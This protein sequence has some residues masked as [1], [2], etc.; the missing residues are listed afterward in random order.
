[1]NF[2]RL[3]GAGAR[4]LGLASGLTMV[5][6]LAGVQAQTLAPAPA[7]VT[8]NQGAADAAAVAAAAPSSR[9][10]IGIEYLH[11]WAK[12]AP[13]SVPLVSTGPE[14][15]K[16]GFLINSNTTILYGAPFSPASGGSDKQSFPGFNGGRLT[17]GYWLD[18]AQRY[19]VEASGFL[20][21]SRTTTFQA[22][23]DANG[24][25]GMRI[26]VFNTIPYAPG[27]GCDPDNAA[28][29]LVPRT[30]DGV[31][32]A[33]PGDLTGGVK[34]TNSL[35]FGELD[36]TAVFPLYRDASWQISGL[37]GGTYLQLSEG[38]NL[39]ADLEGLATSNQYAG[40][41]GTSVDSFKTENRFYGATLGVRGRYSYGP[42][43]V[44]ATERLSLGASNEMLSV[45]GSYVDFNAP[46]A[47]NHGPYG[48]FAMPANEGKT[49]RT[50]FAVVPEVQAKIGYNITPSIAVTIGYDFLY[51]SNVIRPGDQINRNLP[52]GQ[53]FQQD[54]TAASLTSPARL[55]RTT[56]FYA[57]GISIGLV[58]RL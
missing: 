48:I 10:Y 37:A 50:N 31:P 23:G 25:P 5:A 18:D 47:S 26:P 39:T 46:F 9:L 20:T 1:M 17:V 57:Q 52:K 55:F 29:C 6:G 12:G 43:F 32:L 33:V 36:L 11:W 45:S 35:Q 13:L 51:D 19:A 22:R 34:V 49:T 8:Q 38:F 42:M 56:N 41:S 27:G 16:E 54:G 40:Q 3:A 24:N 4:A 58:I 14:M 15:N 53:T 2:G 21:Q 30:E 44:E 28:V 7:P